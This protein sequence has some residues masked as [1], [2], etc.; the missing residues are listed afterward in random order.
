MKETEADAV[1]T[2]VGGVLRNLLIIHF[3]TKLHAT[4]N[5]SAIHSALQV[6]SILDRVLIIY[7]LNSVKFEQC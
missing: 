7:N 2:E 6:K 4:Y 1:K 5:L 3:V